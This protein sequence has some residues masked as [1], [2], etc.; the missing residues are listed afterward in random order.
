MEPSLSHNALY[1]F[2]TP[3]GKARFDLEN[4]HYVRQLRIRR[5]ANPCDISEAFLVVLFDGVL[6]E[7]VADLIGSNVKFHH[8]KLNNKFPGMNVRVEY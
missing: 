6:P 1:G 7:A 4:E 2:D 8:C 3:D 5:V